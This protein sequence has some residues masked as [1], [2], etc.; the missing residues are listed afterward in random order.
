MKDKPHLDPIKHDDASLENV[1]HFILLVVW[2]SNDL[3]SWKQHAQHIHV[4]TVVFPKLYYLR[5][6][7]R[8]GVAVY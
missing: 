1:Q 2:I 4:Y 6:L 8:Y 3:C 7:R 5:Q